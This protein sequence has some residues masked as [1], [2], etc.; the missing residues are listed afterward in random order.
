MRVLPSCS[1]WTLVS[2]DIQNLVHN[3]YRSQ[4]LWLTWYFPSWSLSFVQKIIII[5]NHNSAMPKGNLSLQCV[6]LLTVRNISFINLVWRF[7]TL[8][9][10]PMQWDTWTGRLLLYEIYQNN[11]YLPLAEQI[12]SFFWIQFQNSCIIDWLIFILNFI[13]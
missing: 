12:M 9:D 4:T 3:V 10:F 11:S 5:I 6:T 13:Q 1:Y 2:A 8:A 7:I